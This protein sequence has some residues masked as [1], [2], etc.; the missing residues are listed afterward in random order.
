VHLNARAIEFPFER[1]DPQLCKRITRIFGRLR[2]HGQHGLKHAQRK[3]LQACNTL[4]QRSMRHGR[5][6]TRN[7]G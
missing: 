1:S 6:S 2:K 7:H 5:R 3:A 4:G